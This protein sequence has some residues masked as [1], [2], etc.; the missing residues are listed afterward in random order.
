VNARGRILEK[1]REAL[2]NREPATHPG[3]F[4]GWRAEHPAPPVDAFVRTFEA[5]GG[6]VVRVDHEAHA[7]AWLASFSA[8]FA[9]ATVGQTV[10]PALRP[11]LGARPPDTAD[12]GV[13]M[14]TCAVGETGS[15][16]L[17]AADAR[18]AQLLPPTHVVF[19]NSHDVFATLRDALLASKQALPSAI[20]MH[21]GPSKSAD[22]GQ[23]L[24]KGVH[25][26]GR[27][28]AVVIGASP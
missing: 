27:V 23:I 3:D 18:L 11:P 22:I 2:A 7:G 19:V 15:L 28:I 9:T 13:S 16:M 4:E 5:A 17:S 6:E 1:V 21:S 10:T 12:M 24:V 14:A 25:G 20:G 26:P 8:E